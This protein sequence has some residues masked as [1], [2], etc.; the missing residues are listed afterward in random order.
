MMKSTLKKIYR[1]LLLI[2]MSPFLV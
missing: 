1:T 2:Q